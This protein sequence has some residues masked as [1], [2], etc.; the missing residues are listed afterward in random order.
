MV[1][2]TTIC[3]NRNVWG[4]FCSCCLLHKKFINSISKIFVYII[5]YSKMVFTDLNIQKSWKCT[6]ILMINVC[7]Q[8]KKVIHPSLQKPRK[9]SKKQWQMEIM[10]HLENT[11]GDQLW[12]LMACLASPE[13]K[14]WKMNVQQDFFFFFLWAKGAF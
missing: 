1:W 2:V 12:Q 13:M 5:K 8:K 11:S 10:K 14:E 4:M 9:E 7:N 3:L 6:Q